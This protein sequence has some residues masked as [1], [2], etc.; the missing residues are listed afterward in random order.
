[1]FNKMKKLI[2]AVVLA[3]LVLAALGTTVFADNG[4]H[5]GFSN[6]TSDCASCHRIHSAQSA[7]GF[8]LVANDVYAT[9]ISCHGDGVGAY[10]DVKNGVYTASVTGATLSAPLGAQGDAGQP[11]FGGG[12]EQ[13]AFDHT[14]NGMLGYDKTSTF[15]APSAATSTH[16]VEG[17]SGANGS[18]TIWGAG[19]MGTAPAAVTLAGG[20]GTSLE[21]TSCHDPHGNA[22]W[23]GTA[24]TASYRLL[25]YTPHFSDGYDKQ[26]AGPLATPLHEAGV[27]MTE[28][29]NYWYTINSDYTLDNTVAVYYNRLSGSATIKD[30]TYW[31]SYIT[32][33]GDAA[34]RSYT[35]ARPSVVPA[36]YLV[37]IA[38]NVRPTS[39][40]SCNTFT[41]PAT[42]L[43]QGDPAVTPGT[44]DYNAVRDITSC[45]TV[46]GTAFNNQGARSAVGN[47]CATCHDRYA[48][49]GARFTS[50]GD[51][52][53]KYRHTSATGSV[54]CVDCHAAHGTNAV[55]TNTNLENPGA[56]LTTG[57]I[58]MKT[59]ERSVCLKCHSQSV[60]FGY[61]ATPVAPAPT[62]TP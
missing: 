36:T 3:L 44:F 14:F 56:A 29:S 12:F 55:M 1:M 6:T 2:F 19:L 31:M 32:Q 7:D 53:Y 24:K 50:S 38:P 4:P 26:L 43:P 23:N 10:T 33:R 47:W 13:V 11:L 34:G 35:Y 45:A 30:F 40:Y 48:A 21:C 5:G 58:L 25:R 61:T 39:M 57:S 54:S 46:T 15:P 41:L 27:Q 22:G 37:A 59:D 17:L 16:S 62:P 52:H 42:N 20:V 28:I 60:N 51:A 8:L 18:G 9:C 49:T